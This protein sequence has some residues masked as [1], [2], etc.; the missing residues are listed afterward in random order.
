MVRERQTR[1]SHQSFRQAIVVAATAFLI[2]GAATSHA[3]IITGVTIQDDDGTL[4]NA[5][6]SSLNTINGTGLSSLSFGA[7]SK[8]SGKEPDGWINARSESVSSDRSGGLGRG[9]PS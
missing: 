4:P 9:S 7:K 2:V 6:M 3:E 1:H 8:P 5:Q